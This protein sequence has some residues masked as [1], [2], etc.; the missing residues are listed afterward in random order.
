MIKALQEQMEDYQ[1][2]KSTGIGLYL[3]KKLCDKLGI[4]IELNSIQGEGTEI[5]LIFPKDSYINIQ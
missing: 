2:K 1:I 5:K 3:C 4:A